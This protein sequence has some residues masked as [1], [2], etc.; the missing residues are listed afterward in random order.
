MLLGFLPP[1]Q[2]WTEALTISLAC[3]WSLFKRNDAPSHRTKN[4]KKFRIFAGA[5]FL[6]RWVVL[7]TSDSWRPGDTLPFNGLPPRPLHQA[8]SDLTATLAAAPTDTPAFSTLP[9]HPPLFFL[10]R[11]SPDTPVAVTAEAP[12]FESHP[13]P[14]PTTTRR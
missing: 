10:F 13:E 5:L 11:I 14:G 1:R 8:S 2:P 4:T 12:V 9:S 7:P 3:V 6:F